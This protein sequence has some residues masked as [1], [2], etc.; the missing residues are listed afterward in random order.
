MYGR[1]V[2]AVYIRRGDF[3]R[4]PFRVSCSGTPEGRRDVPPGIPSSH[5]FK[6][7]LNTY[8]SKKEKTLFYLYFSLSDIPIKKNVCLRRWSPAWTALARLRWTHKSVTPFHP[9]SLLFITRLAKPKSNDLRK[10]RKPGF[11]FIKKSLLRL[12]KTPDVVFVLP[13][14]SEFPRDIGK[15]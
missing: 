10:R 7:R 12:R 8:S 2:N 13:N 1:T 9:R 14:G 5:I 3:T 6:I 15:R 11:I 4:P